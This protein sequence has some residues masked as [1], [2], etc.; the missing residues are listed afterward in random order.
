MISIQ[1]TVLRGLCV[2]SL[3][4][5]VKADAPR[6]SLLVFTG[7][8]REQAIDV[9]ALTNH[10]VSS[11]GYVAQVL[12]P[13]PLAEDFRQTAGIEAGK[14]GH[15][16]CRSTSLTLVAYPSISFEEY[17]VDSRGAIHELTGMLDF[18]LANCAGLITNRTLVD[19]LSRQ[20]FTAM[21]GVAMDPCST[22]LADKLKIR[23]RAAYD[24]GAATSLLWGILLGQGIPTSHVAAYGTR[25]GGGDMSLMQRIHNVV[26]YHRLQ[27]WHRRV[28]EPRLAAFRQRHRLWALPAP[29][30]PGSE[31]GEGG[32]G[33]AGVRPGASRGRPACHLRGQVVITGA[34]WGLVEPQPLLPQ[35]K[36]VGPIR[37]ALPEAPVTLAPAVGP[38]AEAMESDAAATAAGSVAGVSAASAVAAATPASLLQPPELAAHVAGAETGVVVIYL[39]SDYRLP[40]R[41]LLAMAEAVIDLKQR[42]VWQ[43]AAADIARVRQ[44]YLPLKH[45]RHV[46]ML[47]SLPL[48]ELMAHP[49]VVSLVTAGSVQAIYAALYVG[50]PVMAVPLNTA[51][52]GLAARLAALGAGQ[53]LS[54]AELEGGAAS[55]RV[56]VAIERMSN[57]YSFTQSM[58]LLSTQLRATL[59]SQSPLERA[60]AW[61]DY[62][63]SLDEAGRQYLVPRSIP[64]GSHSG[65]NGVG[66]GIGTGAPAAGGGGGCMAPLEA[67]NAAAYGMLAAAGLGS[68]ALVALVVHVCTRVPPP[69]QLAAARKRTRAMVKAKDE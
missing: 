41:A 2:L 25:L 31:G 67:A 44:L 53:R 24:D 64:A 55:Y 68:A 34:D 42:I 50:K 18:H 13:E 59:G 22:L 7:V 10:L 21:L 58:Q 61:V 39:P 46:L 29:V 43:A 27:L 17:H 38:K 11:R 8:H 51:Q 49:K 37:A 62:T 19:L 48:R 60:A 35:V 1:F 63:I 5:V 20:N 66:G 40:L 32:L 15:E 26:Q 47:P 52:E 23:R 30:V 69:P 14:P 57:V 65:G 33:P 6:P 45:A 28:Y 3:L 9:W 36:M 12:A 16:D 54:R 56:S 4:H